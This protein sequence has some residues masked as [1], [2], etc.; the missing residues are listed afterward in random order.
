L[1][2]FI[3]PL[4][5]LFDEVEAEQTGELHVRYPLPYSDLI[6]LPKERLQEM[7]RRQ[8]PLAF[9]HTLEEQL[10]GQMKAGFVITDLYEDYWDDGV[11]P[12]NRYCSTFI[13]TRAQKLFDQKRH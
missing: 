6:H 10:G 5:Y 2:G 3:N 12:L 4:L 11:T 1:A 8:D 9:G 7:K 13:A